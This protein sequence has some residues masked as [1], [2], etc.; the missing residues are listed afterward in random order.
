VNSL[1]ARLS[2]IQK[3]LKAPK[4]QFNSFGGYAYRSCHDILEAVKPL[5]EEDEAVLIRDDIHLVG[6]R[7][8]VKAT[9]IFIK[10]EHREESVSFA[11]EPLV[12]KGADE[13]Q[14]TGAASSYAR[15]YALN[16][17]FCI[18]DTK[19]ADATNDHGKKADVKPQEK[20]E[21]PKIEA[22][23][24]KMQANQIDRIK[25]SLGLLTEGQTPQEKGEAMIK[26]CGV[27]DFNDMKRMNNKQLSV[28][29]DK[30]NKLQADIAKQKREGELKPKTVRDVTF[31]LS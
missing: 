28:I 20:P 30:I 26:I 1:I 10:G 18:D 17:L 12:K 5:L 3:D 23:D 2:R 29:I 7:F 15:K 8:Y 6:D 11:R 21:A 19:D 14:I 16:G 31:K 25:M 4:G 24:Y 27:K 13:S 22:T 9:A